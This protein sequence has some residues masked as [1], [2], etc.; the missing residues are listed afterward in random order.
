MTFKTLSVLTLAITAASPV[1]A[2]EAGDIIGRVGAVM[3]APNDSSGKVLGVAGSELEVN[4]NTQLG[5]NGTYML[6]N[7][8][9]IEVLGATPFKHDIKG[10]GS[11]AGLGTIGTTD[12]L[13]PTVTVQYF[14]LS[15]DSALQPYVGAGINH[16]FFFNEK[17]NEKTQNAL[18]AQDIKLHLDSSTGLALEAGMDYNLQNGF[19]I[20]AAVWYIDIETRAD[21]NVDGAKSSVDVTLDP[22][23]Y[24]LS[25][26]KKF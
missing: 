12:H 19:G 13:P 17:I 2:Y 4:S 16:T 8:M 22:W 15:S 14:P 1:M 25:A 5:I 7:H 11:I 20:N 18:G 21:L 3:V 10:K 6:T 23:V 9:G 24:M 26:T